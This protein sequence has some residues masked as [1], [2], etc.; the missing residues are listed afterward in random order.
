M[1]LWKMV[2]VERPY[3]GVGLA[4]LEE[5]PQMYLQNLPH[6]VEGGAMVTSIDPDSAAAKAGLEVQDIII[7]INDT[8]CN[9]F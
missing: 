6:S 9:K 4:S 3:I 7:A 8:E 5:I 2:K 1:K